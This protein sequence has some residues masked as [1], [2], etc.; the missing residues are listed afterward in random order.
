MA[1][2]AVACGGG[3]SIRLS[4]SKPIHVVASVDGEQEDLGLLTT[5][6]T[7]DAEALARLTI[8]DLLELDL[9]PIVR[10]ASVVF[11]LAA[12][13]G[14]RASWGAFD[15]YLRQNLAAASLTL[16]ESYRVEP[17]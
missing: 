4:P 15:L 13:P 7:L 8:G 11:H 17:V 1:R 2:T 5:E 16:V 9:A 6:R 14:V 10:D 12:Q 3:L